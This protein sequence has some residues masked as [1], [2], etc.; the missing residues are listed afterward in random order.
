M[1]YGAY[2]P[3]QERLDVQI[4]RF[5]VNGE[6]KIDHLATLAQDAGRSGNLE[7]YTLVA[8][9]AASEKW[10]PFTNEAATDG[11]AI[12]QGIYVGPTVAEADIAAGDVE[13]FAVLLRDAEFRENWLV[14]ENSKTLATIVTVGTTDLRV[15]RDHLMNLNL[16]PRDVETRTDY[17]T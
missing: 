5:I 7:P 2:R 8:K 9:V 4:A 13:N 14:I 17:E 3:V 15:V 11:S 12:P 10:V 6:P 1:T 16:I